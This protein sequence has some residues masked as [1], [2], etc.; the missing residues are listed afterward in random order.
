M[1][2]LCGLERE[3]RGGRECKIVCGNSD[4]SARG[5]E[6]EVEAEANG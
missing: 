5:R 4:L 1:G 2:W 6:D 3:N